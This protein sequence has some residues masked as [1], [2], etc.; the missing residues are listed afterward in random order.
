VSADSAAS[1]K[2]LVVFEVV[3][4]YTI[5][6]NYLYSIENYWLTSEVPEVCVDAP[7]NFDSL[8][9]YENKTLLRFGKD[10]LISIDAGSTWRS[11]LFEASEILELVKPR[12][13]AGRF[14]IKLLNYNPANFYWT[15]YIVE[16][17]QYLSNCKNIVLKNGRVV[18][19]TSLKYTF[20]TLQSIIISRTNNNNT[21]LT[22]VV[23]E[24]S[25]AIQSRNIDV[26][27]SG[28]VIKQKLP[29]RRVRRLN[30]S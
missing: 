20:G 4:D 8:K 13:G 14:Y 27:S 7:V 25:L 2:E 21:Y 26:N 17:N 22:P 11:T 29:Q 30:A 23:R 19:D 9:V 16:R 24:Y 5:K 3:D 15:E 1:G 10:Y 6:T 12:A 18:F 28:R